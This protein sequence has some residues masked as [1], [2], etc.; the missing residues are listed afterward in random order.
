[1]RKRSSFRSLKVLVLQTHAAR[2]LH[3]LVKMKN[4]ILQMVFS[5]AAFCPHFQ[6][7]KL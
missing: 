4:A 1:M 3:V 6:A 5:T 7:L 2:L